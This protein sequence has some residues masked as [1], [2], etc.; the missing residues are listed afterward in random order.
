MPYSVFCWVS[1]S[2]NFHPH[3][4]HEQSHCM[5]SGTRF[6]C[7]YHYWSI[8]YPRIKVT[9]WLAIFSMFC[10]K[11]RR[12]KRPLGLPVPLCSPK[13][14]YICSEADWFWEQSDLLWKIPQ[15][16][17]N[18]VCYVLGINLKQN[19][20]DLC[21]FALDTFQSKPFISFLGFEICF[22]L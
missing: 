3:C 4:R 17:E 12:K 13:P 18:N 14:F 1:N 7:L 5:H 9:Q 10:C 11:N 15:C 8:F 2:R 16:V 22:Y 6:T 20:E 19:A 21:V